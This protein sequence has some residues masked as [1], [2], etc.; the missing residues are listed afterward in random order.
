MKPQWCR[1]IFLLGKTWEIRGKATSERGRVCIAEAGAKRLVG[2][3]NIVAS[4]H[5]GTRD[6][7]GVWR[8]LGATSEALALFFHNPSNA[9]KR[10][11]A[12]FSITHRYKNAYAWVLADVV[13]YGHP[14]CWQPPRGPVVFANLGNDV[15]L[16][17]V[18][19]PSV[20][21]SSELRQLRKRTANRADS[22]VLKCRVT[23]EVL[24]RRR[25][26][27][28]SREDAEMHEGARLP[29]AV[30]GHADSSDFPD[31]RDQCGGSWSDPFTV[32]DVVLP[33]CLRYTASC[34]E[35]SFLQAACRSLR[36]LI[37]TESTCKKNAFRTEKNLSAARLSASI[38]C[39]APHDML[40]VA[41]EDGG[42][43][44]QWPAAT[45]F[46][47]VLCGSATL[48]ISMPRHV[49]VL[50]LGLK[51][52][53]MPLVLPQPQIGQGCLGHMASCARDDSCRVFPGADAVVQFGSL[54]FHRW[55]SFH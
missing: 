38:I 1:A 7:A 48:Q 10:C 46:R 47:S 21:P 44:V 19:R 50:V 29:S 2:E 43:S 32:S 6:A 12:D 18:A 30:D 40:R 16:P 11:M 55:V 28:L 31:C 23:E 17:E 3:V 15:H 14:V 22:E 5:V 4:L 26:A 36:C 27:S 39:V 9:S 8:P 37:L 52:S 54:A 34:P 24:G 42:V 33:L 41:S 35:L 20:P 13:S 25:C 51:P 53:P 45:A 49:S